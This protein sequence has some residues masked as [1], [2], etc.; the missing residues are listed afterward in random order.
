M[1]FEFIPWQLDVDTESMKL[2]YE[3]DD[4]SK[5]KNL[6]KDF[7]G[8]LTKKQKDFFDLLGVDLSKI[9]RALYDIP[10]D[11]EMPALQMMRISVMRKCLEKH[12]RIQSKF[13]LLMMK[14]T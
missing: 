5:D 3:S 2:F 4:Y 6:N 10:E 8:N 7:S 14:I 11:G 9:D 1:I 12:S 13:Y